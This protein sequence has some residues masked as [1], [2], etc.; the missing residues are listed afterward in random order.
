MYSKSNVFFD[1]IWIRA[2]NAH[3]VGEIYTLQQDLSV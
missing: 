2:D 3:V 1:S